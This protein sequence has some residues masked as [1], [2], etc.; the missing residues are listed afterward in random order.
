MVAAA[1][2]SPLPSVRR[3]L[4]VAGACLVV[5]VLVALDVEYHGLLAQW[6]DR[7]A[8]VCHEWKLATPQLVGPA[9]VMIWFSDA[10]ATYG[11][12][13]LG[14]L[15][16]LALRRFGLA[17]VWVVTLA[18]IGPLDEDWIKPFFHRPHPP[19]TSYH[20]SYS[21]PSANSLRALV[22]Y[23]MLGCL[24]LPALPRRWLRVLVAAVLTVVILGAG[25]CKIYVGRHYPTDV[26]AG[27]A[28]GGMVLG[29]F[30]AGRAWAARLC[31]GSS[32]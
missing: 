14:G 24:V 31:A 16:L 9:H 26:L 32:A 3:P 13:V 17:A 1:S 25:L 19:F 29:L 6:D 27:Y 21:F 12:A 7:A 18:A 2:A 20:A 15:V 11:L 4:F 23:G 8:L 28:L 22:A 10:P 30:M 5:F